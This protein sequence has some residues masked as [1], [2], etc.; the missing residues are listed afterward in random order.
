M[1][2]AKTPKTSPRMTLFK[3]VYLD[4]RVALSPTELHEAAADMDAF[5][6]KKIRKVL[7]GQC[8]T[9]GYVRR[10]STQILARSMGQAE[11]C[12]FTGDFIYHCKIRVLC[13]LPEAGQLV[14]ARILKVSKIGAYAL[15]VDDGKIQEAMRIL[16]PRDFHLGNEEF[17]ALEV[18]QGIKVRLLSSRFQANDAFIQAVGTYE[19]L[20]ATAQ[21]ATTHM[22]KEELLKPAMA[23]TEPAATATDYSTNAAVIAARAALTEAVK[24]AQTEE[25]AQTKAAVEAARAALLAA[26]G[27]AAGGEGELPALAAVEEVSEETNAGT[28]ETGEE[29]SEGTA[30]S[31]ATVAG[32]SGTA[33]SE[34]TVAGPSGTAAEAGSE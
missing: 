8:C 12:R 19:G 33:A 15:I 6:V 29:E 27:A 18:D 17:D 20:S 5:L 30:A 26:T 22:K 1:S 21:A 10:G 11:H 32:P 14:D 31:E 16:V 3:P 25:N 9:H 24:A 7:E 28:E 4:H 13:L 23:A 34:A 2:A